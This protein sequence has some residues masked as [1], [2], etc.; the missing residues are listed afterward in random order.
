[1]IPICQ[2]QYQI[3]RPSHVQPYYFGVMPTGNTNNYKNKL[4]SKP[5]RLVFMQIMI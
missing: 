2:T 3:P 4:A 1:T 5:N